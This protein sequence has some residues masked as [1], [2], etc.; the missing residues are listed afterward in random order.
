MN[1][2]NFDLTMCKTM[3]RAEKLEALID[4]INIASS[5]ASQLKYR[6]DD[7]FEMMLEELDEETV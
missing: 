4:C 3:T 1:Q 7:E 2:I 6:F 5:L